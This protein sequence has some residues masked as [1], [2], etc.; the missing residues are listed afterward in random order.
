MNGTV[1]LHGA[2]LVVVGSGHQ[3]L[4]I[5]STSLIPGDQ[6]TVT[7]AGSAVLNH[8]REQVAIAVIRHISSITTTLWLAT[9]PPACPFQPTIPTDSAYKVGDRLVVH[10][11]SDGSI[12]VKSRFSAAARDDMRCIL[13]AYCSVP[14]RHPLTEYYE[15]H[16][17]TI[18]SIVD[19]T[20]LDTFTIDPESSVDFD[21]AISVDPDNQTIYIHIVDI[22]GND[23]A[24]AL[25]DESTK[26]MRE[27]CL[28]LY[29][30]NEHTEHLIAHRE[31]LD[32][33]SLVKDQVRPVITVR[34][35]LLYGEVQNYDIYRSTIV[36]KRRWNYS[37]VAIALA[38]GTAPEAIRLLA[39]LHTIRSSDVD[40]S[41]AL[42]SLRLTMSPYGLPLSV[43]QES[44]N[45]IAHGL[46]A[47]AMILA[48]LVVS[49]HL[50]SRDVIIPNRFH[51]TLRGY[52]HGDRPVTGH[53][54]VD[55]FILVKRFARA[56]YSIDQRGHFG[57]GLTDYVHF[58]SPMR[59]Y[60]DVLV[61]KLLAGWKV[62]PAI[63]EQEIAW[64]NTRAHFCKVLQDLYTS[65]KVIHWIKTLRVLDPVYCTDVKRAG[66]MWYMPSLLLN[67]FTHVSGL[68][69]SQFW[70]FNEEDQTLCGSQTKQ[71]A[72][73]GQKMVAILNRIDAITGELHLMLS[74]PTP[75]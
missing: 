22:A 68:V 17:Y 33:I 43:K 46:V 10:L 11:H 3:T 36:V 6:V 38:G 28:S 35:Q 62:S 29:L 45:D 64:I 47:T 52:K 23:A 48:N 57:L 74:H 58:T 70:S 18:D 73:T 51:E 20:D 34:V 66:V 1:E 14:D 8:R 42:P 30:A 5:Q 37:E 71:V 16:H 65:W 53:P 12:T 54:T 2:K 55:S 13:D 50:Q 67:G 21:D 19:H 4:Q 59:R 40:Y 32:T 56:Y 9:L 31:S 15:C 26:R 63:L 44:T 27:R 72:I 24:F 41:I 7:S 25:R 60:A 61:H 49:K 39:D 69:P 75:S